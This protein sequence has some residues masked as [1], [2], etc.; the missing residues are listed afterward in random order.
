MFRKWEK[1][2]CTLIWTIISVDLKAKNTSE[3]QLTWA[4][5]SSK[6]STDNTVPDENNMLNFN[7]TFE[8]PCTIY[9]SKQDGSIRPKNIKMVLK[10]FID[11]EKEETKIY[12]KLTIDV[13]KY[14]GENQSIKEDIEM[15]C[16]RRQAPVLSSSFIIHQTGRAEE[17]G[18]VDENDLSFIGDTAEKVKTQLNEWDIT[19]CGDE[20]RIVIPEEKTEDDTP[21][22]HKK[23][24]GHKKRK[25]SQSDPQFLP[26]ISDGD[27]TSGETGVKKKKHARR[28]SMTKKDSSIPLPTSTLEA[29]IRIKSDDKLSDMAQED[30]EIVMKPRHHSVP[31]SIV[32]HQTLPFREIIA[33]ATLVEDQRP[34]QDFPPL[35]A[36][37]SKPPSIPEPEPKPEEKPDPDEL[38]DSV[39]SRSWPECDTP[40]Y[41]DSNKKCAF[42]P[43]VFPIY[44]TLIHSKILQTDVFTDEEFENYKRMFFSLYDM[45][46]LNDRCTNQNRFLTTLSLALLVSNKINL[47]KTVEERVNSFLAGFQEPLNKQARDIMKPLLINF[48]VLCNRFATAKFELGPLLNDYKTVISAVRSTLHFT[49]PINK[50]LMKHFLALLETRMMNKIIENPTRIMFSNAILW[51]SMISAF[52]SDERVTLD[53]LREGVSSLIMAH[54]MGRE[55]KMHDEVC[56]NIEPELCLYFMIHYQPDQMMPQPVEYEPFASFYKLTADIN[57]K[58]KEIDAEL[59]TDISIANEHVHLDQWNTCEVDEMFIELYPYFSHFV[60]K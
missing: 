6:G 31:P 20:E 23:K 10:R 56:P 9:I 21:K 49:Q 43:A 33:P 13:G 30:E 5:G 53:L 35:P 8:I 42:P 47:N 3:F 27:D 18:Q 39:L 2:Q 44:C 41:L 25:H 50:Y 32:Q 45:A 19:E 60:A 51:N 24:L 52:I 55:P 40:S 58:Y 1:T 22:S 12:G 15:E 4:R 17:L 7:A 26:I 36:M 29:K 34:K 46:P 37:S 59:I 28:R 14:Y 16:G 57:A 11:M 54:N 38:F 48:E